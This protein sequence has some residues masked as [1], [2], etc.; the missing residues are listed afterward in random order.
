LSGDVNTIE[1][2]HKQEIAY[3]LLRNI[4]CGRKN[5]LKISRSSRNGGAQR[6]AFQLC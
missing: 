2:T 5:E 3:M 6:R 1:E 4:Y